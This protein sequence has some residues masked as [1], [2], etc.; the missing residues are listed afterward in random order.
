MKKK[1]PSLEDFIIKRDYTGARTF[2]EFTHDC[3]E[4]EQ[5]IALDQWIAFCYF[6][7]GDYHNALHIL[8]HISNIEPATQD[9]NL[10]L[11]VCMFYLGMYE[12]A[13]KL[14]EQIPNTPLKLRLMFHLAHKF[15]NEDQVI[16]LHDSM[17]D[18]VH[19]QLSIASL[20]YLRGHYQEAIDIYKRVLL[21][22]R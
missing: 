8:K 14:V 7:L 12:D 10:N 6:H 18:N 19:D 16:Q 21:D 20:H 13:K 17:Q 5:V 4:E 3:E 1:L 2:L 11:A 22:N 15:N 9:V